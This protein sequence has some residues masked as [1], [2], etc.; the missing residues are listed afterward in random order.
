MDVFQHIEKPTL[1][2]DVQK[3]R[4]NI[5]WMAEKAKKEGV[6]F[7]PHFKTHQS[8]EISG[9]F[10][11]E[12][13]SS[14]TVSSVEMAQ[15]FFQNGWDD[16]LIAFPLNWREIKKI[17]ELAGK[18]YLGILIDSDISLDFLSDHIRNVV[19][20]WIKIDTGLHRVGLAPN[21]FDNVELLIRKIRK[22]P[23]LKFGGLLTHA[24]HSYFS[25]SPEEVI[26][27]YQ[28]SITMMISLQE[29]LM[30][31]GFGKVFLSVGDTPGC[32]L[33]PTLGKIDE[34]RTGN[35]IFY[36]AEQ[37]DLGVCNFDEIAVLAAC[38][39]V[40]K[41]HSRNEVVVFGGAVHLSKEYIE[42]DGKRIY[43]YIVLPNQ[44][45]WGK[46]LAKCYVSAL[47][48][49]HG[50]IQ[51]SE[52]AFGDIQIGDVICIVPI[53]ICLAVHALGFYKTFSGREI[54]TLR[55]QQSNTS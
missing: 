24:G 45:G 55:T 51:L 42:K 36:D 35:F 7:R 2:I 21:D 52:E 10:K 11:E 23:H 29:T 20:V 33:S 28:V 53:H 48:Q 31:R 44:N 6:G 1:V 39:V 5:R 18:I 13:I 37:M 49:E 54:Q 38:P 34:I 9:W 19:A 14:I 26:N 4:N 32:K 41:N 16:I 3:A 47:T 27:R 22:S 40:S 25:L 50:V 17:D 43:G 30:K 8:A 12:N 15:Y 46:P